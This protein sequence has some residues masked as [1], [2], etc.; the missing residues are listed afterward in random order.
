MHPIAMFVQKL[1]GLS[2]VHGVGLRITVQQPGNGA[3]DSP[4]QGSPTT[5]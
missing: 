5:P 3:W 4:T 1:R 2:H